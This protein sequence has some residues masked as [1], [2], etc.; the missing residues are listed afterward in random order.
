VPL[1]VHPF[2]R[3][4]SNTVGNGWTKYEGG[5]FSN[6]SDAIQIQGLCLLT[7]SNSSHILRV[8]HSF[9]EISG[10]TLTWEFDLVWQRIGPEFVYEVLMQL[11]DGGLMTSGSSGG[12]PPISWTHR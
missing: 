7:T 1:F 4:D 11:G 6:T 3:P 9:T 10:G 5:S 12:L 2:T 8:Y